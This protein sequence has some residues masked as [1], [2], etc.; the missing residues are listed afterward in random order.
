MTRKNNLGGRIAFAAIFLCGLV[1]AAPVFAA[2]FDFERMD[3]RTGVSSMK[4]LNLSNL[5]SN[6]SNRQTERI[7][8]NGFLSN[9]TESFGYYK[10]T[11]GYSWVGT[12]PRDKSYLIW[13]IISVPF[14]LGLG[15]IWIPNGEDRY[16]LMTSIE[17]FDCNKISIQKIAFSCFLDIPYTAFQMGMDRDCTR[18]AEPLY[19]GL[20]RKCQEAANQA[21]DKINAALLQA[22]YPPPPPMETVVE[23]AFKELNA[24]GRIPAASRIA[25]IGVDP[26]RRNGAVITAELERLFIRANKFR[27]LDRRNVDAIIAELEFSRS[28][29]VDKETAIQIGGLLGAD[30]IIFGD[31]SDDGTDRRLTFR[32]VSVRTAEVLAASTQSI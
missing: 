8:K 17:F 12:G 16:E 32:A 14:T 31:I 26:S 7:M 22:K 29:F 20:L 4:L 30:V 2:E 21:A 3:L 13:D 5:D 15:S 23:N 28:V 19:R 9:E 27:I 10:I 11:L 18:K 6:I 25:I 24:G 1:S